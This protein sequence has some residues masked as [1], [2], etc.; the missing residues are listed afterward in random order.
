MKKLFTS[1]SLICFTGLAFAQDEPAA[2]NKS[3][4]FLNL[5]MAGGAN[6]YSVS[7][8]V[9]RTHGLLK[10]N[11]LRVGYGLRLSNFGGSNLTYI[12]APAELTANNATID[13][14]NIGSPITGGLNAAIHLGYNISPKIF[15]G[16]NIDAVGIGFG[17]TVI[18]QFESSENNGQFDP[19][20]RA[21]PTA[22][23]LLLVGDNDIGHLKSEFVFS[24]MFTDQFKLRAGGDFTFSEYT[25][26]RTLTND[27]D[28]FR[29]KAMMFFVGISYQLNAND[30]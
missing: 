18:G 17:S 22:Y 26:V 16:F 27:N 3:S 1:L 23:N 13:T 12:T 28:R 21:R 20:V 6:V 2:M 15:V 7:L 29:Y 24:Y 4:S 14:F 5:S 8:G 11:K 30:E 9:N 19:S 25:T 10:T